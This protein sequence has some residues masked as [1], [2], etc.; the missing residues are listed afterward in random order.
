MVVEEVPLLQA[1]EY[2]LVPLELAG[3]DIAVD[4]EQTDDEKTAQDHLVE[5]AKGLRELGVFL[6]APLACC[7]NTSLA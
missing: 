3:A 6:R 7:E 1:E 5:V 2:E 4:E